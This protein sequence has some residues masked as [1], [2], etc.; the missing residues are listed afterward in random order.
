MTLVQSWIDSLQLLK[1]KNFQLF[2][3]V[4][5]KSIIEAYKILL[6]YFWWLMIC[7]VACAFIPMMFPALTPISW[8][9]NL[10]NI[11]LLWFSCAFYSAW[12]LAVCFSTRPS[13]GR[14]DWQYFGNMT[15]KIIVCLAVFLGFFWPEAF[16]VWT[17]FWV[18][19]YADSDGGIKQFFISMWNAFKM[20]VYNFPLLCIIAIM[21]KFPFWLCSLAIFHFGYT[22][23]LLSN[24]VLALYMNSI[25]MIL[26]PIA[27]CTY[28]NIYIKKL[29]DQ[30]DLYIKQPQ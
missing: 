6:R 4:T 22:P 5:L 13:I 26:S 16:S 11:N 29:H 24:P 15:S 19:F 23:I 12:F 28:A 3:M 10:N 9:A 30:F 17:I 18:L 20:L 21:L 14:K 27:I 2:A 1:P 7:I 8:F 25:A